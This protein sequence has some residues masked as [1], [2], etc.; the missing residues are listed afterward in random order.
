MA[1]KLQMQYT[2]GEVFNQSNYIYIPE[3]FRPST[4]IRTQLRLMASNESLT[5]DILYFYSI[6]NE[7]INLETN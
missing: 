4:M 1:S 6:S 7:T 5:Q 3:T 2:T